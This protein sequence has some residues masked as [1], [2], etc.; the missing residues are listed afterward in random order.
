MATAATTISLA[1]ISQYLW[2]SQNTQDSIFNWGGINTER[3]MLLYMERLALQ[4]GNSMS[5]SG[6][7]GVTNYVFS[8]C[9]GKLQ[10]ANQILANGSSGIIVPPSSGGSGGLTPYPITHTVSAGEAGFQVLT[11][12]AWIGLQDVNTVVINQ[13]ILQNGVQFTFNSVTGTFDFSLYSYVLQINDVIS[14]FGF[15]PV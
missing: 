7:Q 3:D 6:L 13:S 11:N 5:L 14:S 2:N 15:K 9:G 12:P 10:I 1:Q 4:Y 8:L